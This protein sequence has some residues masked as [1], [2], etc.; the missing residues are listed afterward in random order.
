MQ[1]ITKQ[2]KEAMKEAIREGLEEPMMKEDVEDTDEGLITLYPNACYTCGEGNFSQYCTKERKDYLGDFPT[3]EV[4]FDLQEIEGLIGT[5]K[6]R[7]IKQSHPQNNP[8]STEKNLSHIRCSRC[9]DS[10]HYPNHFLEKKPRTHGA[11]IV[12]KKPRDLSEILCFQYKEPGHYSDK[13]LEKKKAR[14]E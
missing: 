3:K 11:Y 7:K 5:K 12:T 6:S 14:V 9:K 1:E 2:Q 4:E 8:I 10:C 13:F